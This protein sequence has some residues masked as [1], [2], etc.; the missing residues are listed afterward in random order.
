MNFF[1]EKFHLLIFTINFSIFYI[2][3]YKIQFCF[4]FF[5]IKIVPIVN[6]FKSK[7]KRTSLLELGHNMCLSEDSTKYL[8]PIDKNKI[9]N[10]EFVSRTKI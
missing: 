3:L 6:F 7:I 10:L 2:I 5:V 4:F 1:L 8:V 9:L